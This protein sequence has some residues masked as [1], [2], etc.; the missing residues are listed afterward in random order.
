MLPDDVLLTIFDFYVYQSR[1]YLVESPEFDD[2][3]MKI[4]LWHSL[5]HVC[6]RWR[7][8]VFTSPR[9]L[10]MQLCCTT[11]T[12]A[13]D[14]LDIWPALPL[15]IQGDV[16]EESVNNVIAQL[17]LSDRI[18]Q[19][20]LNCH[21]TSE[22][23]KLWTAMQVPFPELEA[24]YLS[25]RGVSYALVLLDSFL[26]G[27]APRLR[28]LSLVAIPFPGL[29]NLLS[30]ATH[31]VHLHL[32]RIPHSGYISPVAMVTC[33]STL[34]SL[35]NVELQFE[36]PQ[37]SPDQENRRSTSPTR[38]ILPSLRM[39]RFKGVNEYLEDLVARI[40]TPRLHL[41]EA[42][43]FNDIEFHTPELIRF[44]SRSSTLKA[45]NKAH[46][47]FGSQTASVKL[48][49]QASDV[50]YFKVEILCREPD[51][52]LSSLA[53][54]CTM[55]LPLL[56]TTE[57]LFIYE[58][59]DSQLNWKDGI[60]NIEWMELLLPFS[61]VKNLYLSK[62]FAPR[63]TPSLQEMTEGGTTEILP[64]LQNLYLEGFQPSESV[65]GGIERFISTRQL[66]DHP[67]VIS[68]W[69]RNLEQDE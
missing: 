58:E 8:L 29:P 57:N 7:G 26:G 42:T 15:V 34:T 43:F 35:D 19:I 40:D 41:L 45:P 47:L 33:L 60:G 22:I 61:A 2:E 23:E 20:E 6:R 66:T 67:V 63:I 13:R 52:Q 38:S 14:T 9:R 36:S 12:P 56:S 3:D 39:F 44:V 18:C 59:S 11:R 32:L 28:F 4:E 46:L 37:S 25:F 30:F 31:L 49:P 24:L 10:N 27:S 69:D 1:F 48:L 68:V 53:Q 54:I 64:T 16:S 5:L 55:S 21:T 17:K 50:K 51:W 65:E 62:Q